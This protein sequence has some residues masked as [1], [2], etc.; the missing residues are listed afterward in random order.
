MNLV[1]HYHRSR[2][3]AT[4]LGATL[5]TRRGDSAIVIGQ[6]LLDA[7][8]L[9]RLVGAGIRAF[10]SLDL[11]VNNASS[12][13]DTP[14]A[15]T[16]PEQWEDIVGTNL[17][18]PFFLAQAAADVLRE[19]G[20]SIINLVDIHGERPMRG[21]GVYS[22]AK[23]G[24]VMLTRSLALELAPK[25]RV[26]AIAPGAILWSEQDDAISRESTLARIP[27]GRRGEL[28]DIA[29]AVIYL[30][31]HSPYVTGHVLTVDGGRTLHM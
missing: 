29:D 17:R 26:N 23:A 11:L 20:G 22:A 15:T 21:Y 3:D 7:R 25:V 6:D 4:T 14:V 19:A 1:L 10:G 30:A 31:F 28:R 16:T 27:M 5:N 8:G 24:L 12:F 13:F 2:E 18:A 9:P